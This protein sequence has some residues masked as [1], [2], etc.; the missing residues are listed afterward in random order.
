MPGR[1]DDQ[2]PENDRELLDAALEPIISKLDQLVNAAQAGSDAV[3]KKLVPLDEG[4]S[5]D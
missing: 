4:S 2:R 5:D 3:A 1:D